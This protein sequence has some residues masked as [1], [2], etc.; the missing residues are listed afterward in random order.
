MAES[1]ADAFGARRDDAC[2]TV[3]TLPGVSSEARHDIDT[4][5]TT[6]CLPAEGGSYAGAVYVAGEEIG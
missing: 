3:G 2:S 1:V 5:A 6:A 4:G